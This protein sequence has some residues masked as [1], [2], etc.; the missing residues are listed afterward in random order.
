MV[1]LWVFTLGSI[2]GFLLECIFRFFQMKLAKV[3]EV[4]KR[5]HGSF[6]TCWTWKP[7]FLIGPYL[8]IYGICTVF[9]F[10]L[11]KWQPD[12]FWL[13]LVLFFSFFFTELA[14]G[15]LQKRFRLGLWRYTGRF[16]IFEVVSFPY[17][18]AWLGLG[19]LFYFFVIPAFISWFASM[20]HKISDFIL[21]IYVAVITSDLVLSI[22][23]RVPEAKNSMDRWKYRLL[24]RPRNLIDTDESN[25]F[26]I[27]IRGFSNYWK[28]KV[29][30][31]GIL[32]YI[33]GLIVL[34]LMGAFGTL[35]LVL[36]GF[37]SP[38]ISSL[39]SQLDFNWSEAPIPGSVW[40]QWIALKGPL[41]LLILSILW[42]IRLFLHLG[43]HQS[44][45]WEKAAEKIQAIRL[46]ET[47]LAGKTLLT[48][49]ERAELFRFL[50]S[51]LGPT[52]DTNAF[53]TLG[54]LKKRPGK[55]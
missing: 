30:L 9:T 44:G 14:L 15:L 50:Y 36:I 42:L 13:I 5:E 41:L 55:K 54:L 2:S 16:Q 17:L 25:K 32:S 24:N 31:H 52:I 43:F 27:A 3:A 23:Q 4:G 37:N 7:G 39:R 33:V 28:R 35:V 22:K 1:I 46:Y 34:S 40:W 11:G 26:L 53:D 47:T 20:P 48:P 8:P 6:W 51:D 21:G 12:F 19:M 18:A 38:F 10:L 29:I 45:V 49:K